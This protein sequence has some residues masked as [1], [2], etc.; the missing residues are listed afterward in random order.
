MKKILI[1]ALF[2]LPALLWGQ[3]VRYDVEE[4]VSAT[5]QKYKEAC[6]R[7]GKVEVFVIQVI[8]YSG[9]DSGEKARAAVASLNSYL[10]GQGI[11][12]EAY[13]TFQEPNFK[14]RVGYFSTRH[15]AYSILLKLRGMY[16]G[17]F[18]TRDKQRVMT[19]LDE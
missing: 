10:Q 7:V 11:P 1:P 3:N 16:S 15:E 18:V 17:A 6:Q 2:L 14:V 5:E 9:E 4:S 8:A 19:V 13:S 12:A